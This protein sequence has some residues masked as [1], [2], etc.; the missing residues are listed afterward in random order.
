LEKISHL[1][2][3][4]RR[5]AGEDGTWTT[6]ENSSARRGTNCSVRVAVVRADGREVLRRRA[7]ES[8]LQHAE[9]AAA[10]VVVALDLA[11][12][13]DRAPGTRAAGLGGR[14]NRGHDHEA[15]ERTGC[16]ELG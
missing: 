8:P 12:G 2:A 6:T 15:R 7:S 9:T 11:P 14:A 3:E 16:Q 10:A 4:T 13:T 5:L 1:D